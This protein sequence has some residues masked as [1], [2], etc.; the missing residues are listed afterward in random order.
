MDTEKVNAEQTPAEQ[1]PPTQ[2]T[3]EEQPAEQESLHHQLRTCSMLMM[4]LTHS[5]QR[6]HLKEAMGDDFPGARDAMTDFR[7]HAHGH[8]RGGRFRDGFA[9]GYAF[10]GQQVEDRRN[11]RDLRDRRGP[12]GGPRGVAHAQARILQLLGERDGRSLS[13]IVEE[14]DVR[15]S[16]ASELV[17]KLEQHGYVKRE[18]NAED[19]RVTNIFITEE[20]KEHFA[21]FAAERAK[22]DAD[23]FDGLSAEE[24]QQ[25]SEL[26]GKLSASLK[27]KL[28]K[29]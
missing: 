24:Q 9:E 18:T 15:P 8:A 27:E 12:H 14:L 25:L 13:E 7:H 5:A 29:G 16:S 28:S 1:E 22:R 10:S 26:L 23:F 20:G 19:K 4:R 21:A 3:S 6:Q 11:L 2:A 17:S